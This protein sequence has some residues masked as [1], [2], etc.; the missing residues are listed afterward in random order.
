M[1]SRESCSVVPSRFLAGLL[2]FLGAFLLGVTI[3]RVAFV[4][5]R[6]IYKALQNPIAAPNDAGLC[7]NPDRVLLKIRFD[8]ARGHTLPNT[9]L[10]VGN[11]SGEPI[12]FFP[13]DLWVRG[14]SSPFEYPAANEHPSDAFQ[15]VEIPSGTTAFLPVKSAAPVEAIFRYRVGEA[16]LFHS[17]TARFD[18]LGREYCQ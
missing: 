4:F 17:I 14:E 13:Y 9:Y 10:E 16:R 1:Y 18:R 12:Y 7:Q 11:N 6:S 2:I 15:E 5:D 8:V 3:V